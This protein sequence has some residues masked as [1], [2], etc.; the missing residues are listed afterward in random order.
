MVSPF[1]CRDDGAYDGSDCEFHIGKLRGSEAREKQR[2]ARALT[3]DVA[4]NDQEIIKKEETSAVE[5]PRPEVRRRSM[6]RII[7]LARAH[8]TSP[9]QFND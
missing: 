7:R 5:V 2:I 4:G 1:V 8:Y 3:D 6:A 9:D